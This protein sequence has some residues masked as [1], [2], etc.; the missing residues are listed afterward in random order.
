MLAAIPAAAH[1]AAPRSSLP[2]QFQ[3]SSLLPLLV[4]AV[5]P[6]TVAQPP[7]LL[8]RDIELLGEDCTLSYWGNDDVWTYEG[9]TADGRPYYHNGGYVALTGI[10]NGDF[11]IY[12]DAN[13]DG[14]TGAAHSKN[15]HPQWI[16]SRYKPSLTREYDLEGDGTC[17][18]DIAEAAGYSSQATWD[19]TFTMGV[20][21]V[22]CPHA[23]RDPDWDTSVAYGGLV[24]CSKPQPFYTL[25]WS[26]WT[27]TAAK[28]C[29]GDRGAHAD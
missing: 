8:T 24:G 2:F 1:A 6:P 22:A 13:C 9:N 17:V 14:K 23:F 26:E 29:G 25:E 7:S 28:E 19:W 16:M 20:Q 11:Y 27:S 10:K 18:G 21:A 15:G 4:L 3:S 5:A 12:Y